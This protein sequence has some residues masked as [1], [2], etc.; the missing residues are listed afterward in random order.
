LR[1]AWIVSPDAGLSNSQKPSA[2]VYVRVG[3]QDNRFAWAR[4]QKEWRNVMSTIEVFAFIGCI[5]VIYVAARLLI[6][7]SIRGVDWLIR[8]VETWKD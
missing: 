1:F 8:W 7:I 2:R 4:I 6:K 3:A 5:T